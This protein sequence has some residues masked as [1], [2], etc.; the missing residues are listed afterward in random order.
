MH[1]LV[2]CVM[3][4]DWSGEALQKT[5][6]FML[7]LVCCAITPNL[8]NWILCLIWSGGG[9]SENRNENICLL[10]LFWFFFCLLSLQAQPSGSY[11]WWR[12]SGGGRSENRNPSRCQ[13]QETARLADFPAQLFLVRRTAI[14]SCS[15]WVAT[16]SLGS[17]VWYATF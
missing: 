3:T 15:F 13:Q 2:P 11:A 12:W 1:V 7:I 9:R 14:L 6:I 16:F 5:L 4:I 8:A 10:F 17:E